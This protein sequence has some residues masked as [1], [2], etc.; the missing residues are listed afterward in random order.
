MTTWVRW[1]RRLAALVGLLLVQAVVV[2]PPQAHAAPTQLDP[3]LCG[4]EP[5]AAYTTPS[6]VWQFDRLKPQRAWALTDAQ[7]RK[8]DGTGVK[9]AVLDTGAAVTDSPYFNKSR[10]R[11]YNLVGDD[12][13]IN[14]KASKGEKYFLDCLHGTMVVSLIAGQRVAN[15]PFSGMAPGATVYAMR[16]LKSSKETEDQTALVAGMRAA[17]DMGV[18][19]INISQAGG[20]R[21]DLRTLTA[22]AIAKGIVVVAATGNTGDKAGPRYPAAYPGV[23]AVGMSTMTDA[24]HAESGYAE[25]MAV[26]VAAPG[27]DVIGLAPSAVDRSGNGEYSAQEIQEWQRFRTGSGTSFSTP[28]VAGLVALMLQKDPDL[29]PAQ[30]KARLQVSADPPMGTIPDRQLGFGIVNPLLA[31][32]K[33]IPD[34]GVFTGQDIEPPTSPGQLPPPP[35]PRPKLIAVTFGAVTTVLV[36]LGIV[37]AEAVPAMIRRRFRPAVPDPPS[38]SG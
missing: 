20:P 35:D 15:S 18:D 33:N 23:I 22:E 8:L 24:P 7:G 28:L 2:V 37:V 38:T 12:A 9:I 3:V 5:E 27:I 29:T 14:Q 10:L 1:Q 6:Q 17:I 30:V 36:M 31:L 16:V 25:G 26:T 13:D 4:G 32:T 21:D 19:V 11:S 34:V